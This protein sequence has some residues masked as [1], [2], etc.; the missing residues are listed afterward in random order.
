LAVINPRTGLPLI[1]RVL[2]REEAYEGNRVETAADLILEPADARYLPLGDI[3]WA[4]HVRRSFQSGWHRRDSYWAGVG[5]AF[6][7]GASVEAG[8]LDI[9]PTLANMLGVSAPEFCRG[10][11]LGGARC[12]TNA[13]A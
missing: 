1:G 9:L 7:G 12:V 11:R 13:T 5:P 3:M 2:R 10:R 8:A 4:E 6:D